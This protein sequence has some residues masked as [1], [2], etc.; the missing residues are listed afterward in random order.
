MIHR[1]TPNLSA[2]SDTD[3]IRNRGYLSLPHALSQ[4]SLSLQTDRFPFFS[5]FLLMLALTLLVCASQASAQGPSVSL[6]HVTDGTEGIVS[7]QGTTFTVRVSQTGVND[8]PGIANAV[9]LEIDLAFD[10]SVVSLTTP[11]GFLRADNATGATLTLLAFPGQ[12]LTVP[13][14]V[15]LTFTTVADVTDMEFTIGIMGV[16]TII[17]GQNVTIPLSETITFNSGGLPPLEPLLVADAIEVVVPAGGTATATVTAIN[18]AEGAEITFHVQGVHGQVTSSQDGVTLTLMA[19]GPATVTVMATDGTTTTAPVTIVFLSPLLLVADAIEVVVPAGG[20]ATAT[21]TAINFAEGAEITFHVQGVHGQVTSSQD[22]V[23][24]TLMASGPATVTVTATDGTTTTAPVTIVFLNSV[25]PPLLDPQLHLDTQ[26]ESPAQNNSVL[27][28]TDKRPGGTLQ[29]QLFVPNAAGQDIQAFTLE[30]ALQGKTFANFISSISGSDW[31]GEALFS[32]LS[33]S[34]NPT[35]S[36]LFLNAA[37]VPGTGYLGQIDLE[38]T[39]LLTDE[40]TLRVTSVFLAVAGGTLQSV[41]VSNAALS[42]EPICPGDFDDNGMVNMADFMLFGDVFGTQS[43]DATYNAL[44]DMDSNGTIDVADFMLFVDVFDTTCEQQPT[45]IGDPVRGDRAALVALYNATNGPNWTNNTNWL[46]TAPLNQWHGVTTDAN[47]RVTRLGLSSNQLSGTIPSELGSLTNLTGLELYSNQL[48]GS[49][50]SSLGSLTNLEALV[51]DN[52]AGL[53][54]PLPGSF[55]GLDALQYLYMDGTGLCAPTDA[56]FQRW[57]QGIANKRGVVNCEDPVAEDRAA[58]VALYNATN[59]PNWSNNTNWLSDR[60]LGEWH[61]VTTD[62]NGRVTR[63][64]LHPNQLSGTIPPEVGQLN[65]LQ[66]LSLSGNQLSGTIPPEVGQLNNLQ[67]LYLYNN[68]LSG[69][70][71]PEVGQLNNLQSLALDGNQLSGTIPAALGQLNN[72]QDLRLEGNAG[73]SGALPG[74][75]TAL[76]ALNLLYVGGT[77]LCAPVDAAFQTW[78]QGIANKRG[79][80][81]CGSGSSGSDFAKHVIHYSDVFPFQINPED[82]YALDFDADG[83]LDILTGGINSWAYWHENDGSG[84]FEERLIIS[85]DRGGRHVYPVDVDGD[86][87]ADVF[88]HDTSGD[89]LAWHENDGSGVFV[90]RVIATTPGNAVLHAADLDGDGDAD[91]LAA[92]RSDNRIA[93]YENVGGV[94]VE[95]N[96]ATDVINAAA[97]YVHAADLDGD[98]DADVVATSSDAYRIAWYE[99]VG[100]AFE[101]R[102]AISSTI[103][104]G[105]SVHAADL[106]GDG[107]ADVVVASWIADKVA[108]YENV[109]GAFEERVLS[110]DAD[111]AANAHAADLDGDGDADVLFTTALATGTEVAWYENV[112]GAF[113]ERVLSTETGNV[114]GARAADLDGDG[115]LDVLLGYVSGGGPIGQESLVWH[116]NLFDHGDDHGDTV[117]GAM[118]VTALP[119]FLHGVLESVGDGDVFRVATGSGTLRVYSNGPTNTYGTLLDAD[120]A[121]LASNDDSGSGNNFLIEVEVS[122]G[123]HYVEVSGFADA[124]TGPY[125]LS[126]EFVANRP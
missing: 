24:L 99:N 27:T 20:T 90:E 38:L 28:F 29:I 108:W 4:P 18:F 25:R 104:T 106:D 97:S 67:Y 126:I 35:L 119:A 66:Y 122:A 58:L 64:S 69:T 55:T 6:E 32:G 105:T 117:D 124:T 68:Q 47:G 49:I 5:K 60:P 59:G 83:D 93:W 101:E 40:D 121:Q 70:I 30:L 11:L 57:L 100:G 109:G 52:N 37:T 62:A 118:L 31:M 74:S 103:W 111:Y 15:D 95:R 89:E 115:D 88:S 39:G 72:L 75:F 26:I 82:L 81:N 1:P 44:M 112:G 33:A 50:P 13:A 8:I 110:N 73:L 42:F 78:L 102:G 86:G 23:T 19:S 17:A 41:D 46:S 123:V 87:D 91:L 12:P 92:L 22:G 113:E 125:T 56:A 120:G 53:S 79:V 61:G 48:S 51:L 98:G 36:G 54:G 3:T 45:G 84:V 94:F 65:N 2:T 21:V 71:P 14:S 80:V 34:D 9:V 96:I 63:L 10:A 85:G 114:I 77:G 16:S 76:D 116:E 43:G 7:G 107:D